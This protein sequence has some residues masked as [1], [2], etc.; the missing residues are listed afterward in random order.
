MPITQALTNYQATK[1]ESSF[2]EIY[3]YIYSNGGNIVKSYAYRYKLD[4][5][6]VESMINRKLFDVANKFVGESDK[7]KNAVFHAVKRGCIDVVRMRNNREKY[8]TEV[9]WEDDDG[10]LNEVYELIEVAPTTEDN[11]I[12]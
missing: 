5:Q 4:E 10:G 12:I 11:D 8:N 2:S 1:C 6:D 7:F 9:L 3:Y